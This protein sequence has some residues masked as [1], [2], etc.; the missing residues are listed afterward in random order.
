VLSS[1]VQQLLTFSHHHHLHLLRKFN[2]HVLYVRT[3]LNRFVSDMLQIIDTNDWGNG[4][5]Y[6]HS[7]A[8]S[9][10]PCSWVLMQ[11]NL[12]EIWI[13]ALLFFD[14]TEVGLLL[15]QDE[16]QLGSDTWKFRRNS[17]SY[18]LPPCNCSMWESREQKV[19][20]MGVGNLL[21]PQ[22]GQDSLPYENITQNL[23]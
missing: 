20:P 15:Q 10:I 1:L 3:S 19:A 4:M 21:Q 8:S 11:C 17:C 2:E 16:L 13:Q 5:T 6:I 12:S 9:N 22:T 23:T 7:S 14:A 18:A